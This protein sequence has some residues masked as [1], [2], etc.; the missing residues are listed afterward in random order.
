MALHG[1]A[2]LSQKN[3]IYISVCCVN[4]LPGLGSFLETE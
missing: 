1:N 2:T 4:V 3:Y